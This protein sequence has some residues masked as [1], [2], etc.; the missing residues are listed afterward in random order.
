MNR[1]TKEE[2]NLLKQAIETGRSQGKTNQQIA[3]TL[4]RDGM[5]PRHNAKGV[6]IKMSY[7]APKYRKKNK[8]PRTYTGYNKYNRLALLS[9]KR[10]KLMGMYERLAVSIRAVEAQI[11]ELNK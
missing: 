8:K 3:E 2:I 7:L 11:D 4:D 1:W 5:L 10:V 9:E 6:S